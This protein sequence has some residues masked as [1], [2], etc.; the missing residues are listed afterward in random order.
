MVCVLRADVGQ[1]RHQEDY[2][3]QDPSDEENDKHNVDQ[4][5]PA[6][7]AVP[8]PLI[9]DESQGLPVHLHNHNH[10]RVHD[11]RGDE[12]DDDVAQ[13]VGPEVAGGAIHGTA[14]AQAGALQE[15]GADR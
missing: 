13:Q 9:L 2:A 1:K 4:Q 14:A 12:G 6:Q 15:Q 7:L 5:L 11:K 3:Q 8:H 10:G